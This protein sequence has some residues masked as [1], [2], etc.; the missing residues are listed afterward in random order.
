MYVVDLLLTG[1][2]I[3]ALQQNFHILYIQY[4]T[5]LRINSGKFILRA[6]LSTHESYN[7]YPVRHLHKRKVLEK[8]RLYLGTYYINTLI[9]SWKG[10]NTKK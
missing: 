8:I 3:P 4:K 5:Y 9:P 10:V 6:Q 7:L 2:C 1:S